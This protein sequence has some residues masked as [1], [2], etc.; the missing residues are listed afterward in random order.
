MGNIPELFQCDFVLNHTHAKHIRYTHKRFFNIV[1]MNSKFDESFLFMVSL[2][3][4][5]TNC[6]R[7]HSDVLHRRMNI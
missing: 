3:V 1:S 7:L 2:G 5:N 4:A 6:K